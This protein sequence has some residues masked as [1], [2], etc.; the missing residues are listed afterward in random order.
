MEYLLLAL[1]IG[2]LDSGRFTIWISSTFLRP[3]AMPKVATIFDG[4]VGSFS[5]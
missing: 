1:N 4:G 5:L 2:D 3:E